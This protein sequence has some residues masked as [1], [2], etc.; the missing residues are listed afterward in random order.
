MVS[1]LFKETLCFGNWSKDL[2]IPFFFTIV[3]LFLCSTK[4]EIN[5]YLV[6]K[7]KTTDIIK[8]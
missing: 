3:L 2:D 7:K 6:A 1:N 4:E 5:F 8:V